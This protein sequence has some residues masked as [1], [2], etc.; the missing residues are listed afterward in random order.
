MLPPQAVSRAT[1]KVGDYLDELEK[2]KEE[3]PEQVRQGLEAFIELWRRAVENGV[4][5]LSDEVALAL[6]KIEAKGGLLKA[7]E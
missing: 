1:K 3:R 5:E 6:E 4:V 2:G 7:A